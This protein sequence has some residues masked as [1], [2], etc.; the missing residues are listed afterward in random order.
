MLSLS[1]TSKNATFLFF[2]FYVFSSTKSKNK[3]AKKVLPGSLEYWHWWEGGGG[4]ERGIKMN[5]V[6]IVYT[7]V[8]K[9]KNDTC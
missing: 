9:S 8:C 4:R 3:R 7:H 5:T 6:Q 1:Q 2:I